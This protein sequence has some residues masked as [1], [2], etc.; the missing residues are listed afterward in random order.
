MPK[1]N[2]IDIVV[3]IFL[4]RGGYIGL[5]KGF[6]VE[7]FKILGAIASVVFS[8]IYYKEVGQWLTSHSFLSLQVA[9]V[10]ALGVL[11]CLSLIV[12]RVVRVLIFRV[13]HLELFYGLEKWGGI[14]LG[15]GRSVVFA[16]LFLFALTLIPVDYFKTAVEERSFSGP[17]LKEVAPKVLDFIVRFRPKEP[18][19]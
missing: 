11:F 5:V 1:T 7:I 17:Y 2:W 19:E 13:L 15:L 8:L 16:S 18:I 6:S 4:I 10:L 14:I 3:I 12:L 9:D